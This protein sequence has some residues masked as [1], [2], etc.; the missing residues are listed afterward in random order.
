MTAF[1]TRGS[2]RRTMF[3]RFKRPLAPRPFIYLSDLPSRLLAVFLLVL[4]LPLWP[5]LWVLVRAGVSQTVLFRQTRM[6]LDRRIFTIGKFRTMRDDRGADGLLLSDLERETRT[7]RF[8]RRTRLD[9]LPQLLAI[10]GG[11]MAFIGPRPLLPQTIEA[12]GGLGELRCRVRPG[13]TGWAQVNGNTRLSDREKLALDLWYI[14]HRSF[15]LDVAVLCRT[16]LVPFVGERID[17]ANL[18]RAQA[19]LVLRNGVL[20]FARA[21]S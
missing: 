5:I 8:L 15:R 18:R 7:G 4:S 3:G 19:D 13:L 14:A 17:S 10:A 6:G 9:E 12:F 2:P 11:S 21:A 1:E 20:F 16:V